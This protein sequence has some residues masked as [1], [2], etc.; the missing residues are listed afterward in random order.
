M[1]FG[2]LFSGI[3]GMDLGLERAGMECRWQVE[4]D[5]YATKVLEKHWPGVKRYGDIRTVTDPEHVDLIAGGFPCQDVSLAGLRRGIS[6]GTRSGLYAQMLRIVSE[7]RP[8]VVLMENVAGLLSPTASGEPALISRVLGDLAEIGFDSEWDCIPASSVGA[9]HCRDRV[10]IV[11]YL[12]H[13]D[14]QEDEGPGLRKRYLSV[15]P[16]RVPWWPSYAGI[17]RGV[18]GVP[19]WV[20]RL[21]GCGNAVVPQVAEWLGRRII[22]A[23]AR[24]K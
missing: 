10:F 7:V 2:S 14:E 21:K 5:P 6:E 12:P 9:P 24:M 4:I 8:R 13:A 1:T 23:D 22:E 17:R 19:S 18:D 11:S 15:K 16:R 20:D 3:G